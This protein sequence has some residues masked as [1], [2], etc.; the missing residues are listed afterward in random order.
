[1]GS[2]MSESE[3]VR[4]TD[5]RVLTESLVKTL[6]R[7]EGRFAAILTHAEV[8]A[9]RLAE[10]ERQRDWHRDDAAMVRRERDAEARRLAG[11]LAEEER[12]GDAL[13]EALAQSE[14]ERL[15]LADRLAE[16]EG[17]A[18]PEVWAVIQIDYDDYAVGEPLS[19]HWSEE[20]AK[21]VVC[22]IQ[23]TRTSRRYVARRIRISG[24]LRDAGEAAS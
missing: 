3:N 9:Q 22:E 20:A 4:L 11:E 8:L 12:A 10:A 19:Y 5:I 6:P 17:R 14:V 2:S 18:T 16:A 13:N 24:D 1:M 23:T 7:Y 21:K 15:M